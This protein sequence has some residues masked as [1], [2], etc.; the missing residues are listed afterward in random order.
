MFINELAD[1][2]ARTK[3]PGGAPPNSSLYLL[4]DI[5]PGRR[6]RLGICVGYLRK[7][8]HPVKVR[9]AH[10]HRLARAMAAARAAHPHVV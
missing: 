3:I 4:N 2:W 1:R 5:I 9:L 7:A 8:G 10:V 6:A